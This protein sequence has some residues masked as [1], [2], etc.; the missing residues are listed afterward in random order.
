[1]LFEARLREGIHD[2]RITLMVR[3]WA[4]SKAIPGHRYRTGVDLI[5]VEEV[6]EIA[7]GDLTD[8]DAVAAGYANRAE[9]IANL[10]GGEEVPLYRV[11][12]RVVKEGDPRD[13]LAAAAD[14]TADDVAAIDARLQRFDATGPK[15]GWTRPTLEAIQANPGLRA[16]TLAEQLGWQELLVFKR[17]VRKLKDLGLTVSLEVGYRVSP[18]GEAYLRLSGRTR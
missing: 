12:F 13:R 1:M 15:P 18:R 3:R 17:S 7:E 8:E 4:R 14:L 5:E 9:L 16:G 2:G 10:R 11:R 6:D